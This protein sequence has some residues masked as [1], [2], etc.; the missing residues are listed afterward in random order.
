MRGDGGI[1]RVRKETLSRAWTLRKSMTLPEILLWQALRGKRFKDW[2]FRRQMPVGP[3]VAD[4]S[5]V[6]RKLIIEVDGTSHDGEAAF[7]RDEKRSAYL[8]S[9]GFA[10][11]RIAARDILYD[12][13]GVLEALAKY[14]ADFP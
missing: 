10:I 11:Y 5:C 3:N 8:R 14:F 2:R 9:E 12:L 1:M 13:D 7:S 6:D 4:F